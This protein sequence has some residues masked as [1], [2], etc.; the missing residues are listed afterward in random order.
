MNNSIIFDFETTNSNY[1]S[2]FDLK[3]YPVA[4]CL[5][6]IDR[7]GVERLYTH[8]FHSPIGNS[9]L[10]DIKKLFEENKD[11]TLC[12][13]YIKF[14]LHWLNNLDIDHGENYFDTMWVP[15]LENQGRDNVELSLK[16]LSGSKMDLGHMLVHTYGLN[17][18]KMSPKMVLAYCIQDVKATL[19]LYKQHQRV[20]TNPDLIKPFKL[21]R[22]FLPSLL[23]CER[24][25]LYVNEKEL[26]EI[27]DKEKTKYD[28]MVDELLD[29][30][31]EHHNITGFNLNSSLQLSQ[32]I[33]SVKIIKSK[34][35]K[36]A[37]WFKDFNPFKKLAQQEFD[38]KVEECFEGLDY[39][40]H[41]P[42][43]MYAM[44]KTQFSTLRDHLKLLMRER[45]EGDDSLLKKIYEISRQ[46][47]LIS[48]FIEAIIGKP[49]EGKLKEKPRRLQEDINGDTFL[50]TQYSQTTAKTGR[51]ASSKINLQNLPREGTFPVKRCIQSRFEGGSILDCDASQIEIRYA[52][53]YYKDPQMYEDYKN[54]I[55]IH[56][57]IAK[58]AYGDGFTDEQRTGTKST[59]FRVMYRGSSN[60]IVASAQIPIWTKKEAQNVIDSIYKQYPT[61]E[62]GQEADLVKVLSQGYLDTPTGR[63]FWF[64]VCDECIIKGGRCSTHYNLRNRV[65]NY[66]IQSGATA[67]L[68]PC[69]MI[70]VLK[71]MRIKGVKSLMIAQVHDSIIFDVYPGE[72][73]LMIKIAKWGLTIG[74]ER[75][76]KQR[77]GFD[78]GFP[79]DS[80][81]KLNSHW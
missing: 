73:E 28:L 78:F 66:P 80:D 17:T 6:H 51:L 19:E 77:Y 72:E 75:E 79:L 1:G 5:I 58:K 44:G 13:H 65:A 71:A 22:D 54:N 34:K 30:I 15:Y 8:H 32:F 69:G 46:K 33:Y 27:Y 16:A 68:I 40:L 59:T 42:P 63:R 24:N 36:W 52:G 3:N 23:E 67:D 25:G 39:G 26:R 21:M 76:W 14:D 56:A 70:A 4:L 53:Q 45:K 62:A 47:T 43:P 29:L 64:T 48:T 38:A 18:A 74:A 61:F 60:G 37:W 81:Y 55:D 41:I 2:P 10:E 12:G 31:K 57:N 7:E 50:H 20:Y 9:S 11:A 49:A 35:S